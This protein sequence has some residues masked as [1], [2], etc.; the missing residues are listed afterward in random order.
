MGCSLHEFRPADEIES[1]DLRDSARAGF[2]G[3]EQS[4]AEAYID[5]LHH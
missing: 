1:S 5:D 4:I 2:F 3:Y